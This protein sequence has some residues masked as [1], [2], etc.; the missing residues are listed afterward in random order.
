MIKTNSLKQGLLKLSRLASD[1][2]PPALVSWA[3][4]IY[5]HNPPHPIP[6]FIFVFNWFVGLFL[7]IFLLSNLV[8]AFGLSCPTR[9]SFAKWWPHVDRSGKLDWKLPYLVLARELPG[10]GGGG[11]GGCGWRKDLCKGLY[12]FFT[13]NAFLLTHWK[14]WRKGEG[15]LERQ[16]PAQ[17]FAGARQMLQGTQEHWV[18]RFV[19]VLKT[20]RRKHWYYYKRKFFKVQLWPGWNYFF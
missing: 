13:E 17:G 18:L 2:S 16:L 8:S 10:E 1:F 5:R 15:R 14:S 19:R 3:G 12:F 4:W 6:S 20:E 7:N 9:P 11:C